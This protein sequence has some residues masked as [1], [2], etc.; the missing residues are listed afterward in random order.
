MVAGGSPAA[1]AHPPHGCCGVTNAL[2]R[3]SV[4]TSRYFSQSCSSI[5]R[6]QSARSPLTSSINK[7]FSP[8]GLQRTGWFSFLHRSLLTLEKVVGENPSK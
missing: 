4:L 6:N 5:S 7:A 8:S 1:V 2:L 3:S